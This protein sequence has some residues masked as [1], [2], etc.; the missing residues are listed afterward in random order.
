MILADSVY[1]AEDVLC[2][3]IPIWIQSMGVISLGTSTCIDIY[4]NPTLYCFLVHPYKNLCVLRS[5]QIPIVSRNASTYCSFILLCIDLFG[6]YTRM[7]GPHF[8]LRE[9]HIF[10]LVSFSRVVWVKTTLEG[11]VKLDVSEVVT[12]A[13]YKFRRKWD[14]G[15]LTWLEYSKGFSNM[16]GGDPCMLYSRGKGTRG[17]GNSDDERLLRMD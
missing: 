16:V 2:L 17:D 9:L 10:L 15:N 8:Y 4:N 5:E 1:D 13:F 3:L 11:A 7:W 6:L 12:Q 14:Q